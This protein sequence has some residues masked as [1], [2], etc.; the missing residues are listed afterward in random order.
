MLRKLSVI[1]MSLLLLTLISCQPDSVPEEEPSQ[2]GDDT[3]QTNGTTEGEEGT[4]AETEGAETEMTGSDYEGELIISVWGGT[5]EEWFREH[6]E[7]RFNQLYPNVEVIY[8]V[9][10]MSARYNK[11][12]AQKDSPEIDLFV[13]T[14]EAAISAMQEGLLVPINH[15]NVPNMEGLYDW[16]LPLP[17]YGAAYSAIAY[18]LAYNPDFFGDNPPTS[19][20]DLWRPR[21]RVK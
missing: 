16:A 3:E 14:S 18:V 7:P 5:T 12:L 13:S 4:P 6:V 19:W 15:E 21:Y 8:D 11:L 9:G 20:N 2:T 1:L 10:G 17:E